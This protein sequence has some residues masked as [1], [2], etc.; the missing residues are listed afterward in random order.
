[1]PLARFSVANYRC[2]PQRQEIELRPIT[3]VLGKNN[4]GKSAIVRAPLV[5]STGIITDSPQPLDLP[6]LGVDPPGFVDLV[7]KRLEHGSITLSLDFDDDALQ[8]L[9]I[10][11]TIQNIDE[12][13][14]Q[15]VSN[16]SL[17]AGDFTTNLEWLVAD[18]PG[19]SGS[20]PYHLDSPEW[21]GGPRT[22]RF[23]GLI[24]TDDQVLG[25]AIRAKIVMGMDT[26]RHLGPFRTRPSRMYQPPPRPLPIAD[27]DIGGDV[28]NQLISDHVHHSG[29][30]L[31]KVNEYLTG[32]LAG[33]ELEVVPRLGVYAL[34]LKSKA[35]R[36]VWVS[37][38]DAGT[39]VAQ[40]LP[41]LVRRAIDELDPPQGSILEIVEEP[42]L[43][44]HP[45][46][47]AE[48]ADLYIRAAKR[49]P[50]RF[51]IET[52][53]ETFLLRLRRRIAEGRLDPHMLQLYFVTYDGRKAATKAIQVDSLG[54]VDYWPHGIFSEDFEET[55]AIAVAQLAQQ[56]SDAG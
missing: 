34:G 43:H 30:L 50:A 19:D 16:W 56:D 2:F 12:W 52:H 37:L 28:A 5:L 36:G 1:M 11:A 45:A 13:Q 33:W 54:N 53:S 46:A 15:V 31:G 17:R 51:I 48:L 18:D 6:Q 39:G 55:K 38:A 10:E 21:S 24:P 23:E 40:V 44:L 7:H 26:I 20:H 27:D 29:R 49:T 42:E 25:E 47:Q 8:P 41:I 35:E 14:T 22:V 9:H 4:S 32:H 3:V